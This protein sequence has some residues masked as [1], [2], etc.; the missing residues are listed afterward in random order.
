M[1]NH[2]NIDAQVAVQ[3]GS[4]AHKYGVCMFEEPASPNPKITQF[5]SERVSVPIAHG[6]RIYSRWGYAPY[7][8]NGSIQMI[9]PDLGNCGGITEGKKICD[10]AY[11]YDVG[12]QAHVCGSPLSTA[13]AL[14]LEAA[15][16]N[17]TIHEHHVY[18]RY[19][20][21]RRLCVR[22]YQPE[23][24]RF[25]MPDLPGLGNELAEYCWRAGTVARVR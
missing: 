4:L 24:G 21:N 5:V 25:D 18:A 20:Y 13:A 11:T 17:F 1:E 22:D 14:Q 12:V 15:I 2:A 10:M 3:F 6:E 23:N 7:F 16:P 9:Q 19:D 8:E